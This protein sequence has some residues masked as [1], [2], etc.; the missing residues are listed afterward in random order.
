MF[1]IVKGDKVIYACLWVDKLVDLDKTF[2]S[3]FFSPRLVVETS[4]TFAYAQQ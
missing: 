3:L 1:Y 2:V 4:F